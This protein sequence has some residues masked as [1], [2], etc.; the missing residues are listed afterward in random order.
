MPR[1]ARLL[2]GSEQALFEAALRAYEECFMEPLLVALKAAAAAG[3]PVV[4]ECFVTFSGP[5]AG[6][7]RRR[8]CTT[9]KPAG[10]VTGTQDVYAG[11][12]FRFVDRYR[13]VFSNVLARPATPGARNRA[14]VAQPPGY[15]RAV[16][17]GIRSL[18]RPPATG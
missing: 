3:V 16:S 2:V 17:S 6:R 13:A 14:A 12:S 11:L 18:V 10:G 9:V 15:R 4:A 5:V 8:G 1:A 7:R